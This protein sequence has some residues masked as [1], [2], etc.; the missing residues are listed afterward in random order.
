VSELWVYDTWFGV[1]DRGVQEKMVSEIKRSNFR[2]GVHYS[3]HRY[4]GV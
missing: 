3:R 1:L 2:L 4:Q